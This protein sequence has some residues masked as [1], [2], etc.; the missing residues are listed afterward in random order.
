MNDKKTM[1]Y[2]ACPYTHADV[3]VSRKRYELVTKVAGW[4]M[5]P[6][7]R[8]GRYV[9]ISPITHSHPISELSEIP[10]FDWD[11]WQYQDF[12]LISRCDEFWV[13]RIPGW[14]KSTGVKDE[15]K[16]V[17]DRG[18]TWA[19][20]YMDDLPEDLQRLAMEL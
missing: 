15:T 6:D 5:R 16:F 18:M 2:L 19:W 10:Q 20:L 11:F 8:L 3:E 4:L 17:H 14:H 7:C 9:V 12:E 13:L 1:I